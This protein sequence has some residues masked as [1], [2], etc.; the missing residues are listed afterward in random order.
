MKDRYDNKEHTY[1]VTERDG[2]NVYMLR[3]DEYNTAPTCNTADAAL[4]I[5]VISATRIGYSALQAD[6]GPFFLWQ[7][8]LPKA[9]EATKPS[10]TF[11]RA[12]LKKVRDRY[13]GIKLFCQGTDARRNK[14]YLAM[15]R[16][17]G[18]NPTTKVVRGE[19][20]IWW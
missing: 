11:F 1:T 20:Q 12:A 14:S 13:P 18:Y 19:T 4:N 3:A 5:V 8:H 7:G 2:D 6:K 15:L 17:W 9:W 10:L 16:R